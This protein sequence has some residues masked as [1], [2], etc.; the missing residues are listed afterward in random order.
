LIKASFPVIIYQPD[1][2]VKEDWDQAA[3]KL[4][5]IIG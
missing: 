5:E 4:A 1:L 3:V 2:T